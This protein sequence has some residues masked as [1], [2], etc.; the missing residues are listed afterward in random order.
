MNNPYGPTG[1]NPLEGGFSFEEE[2][3]DAP[4]KRKYKRRKK[5]STPIR[6]FTAEAWAEMVQKVIEAR[7]KGWSIAR[8]ARNLN[9]SHYRVRQALDAGGA[10]KMMVNNQYTIGSS[11]LGEKDAKRGSYHIKGESVTKLRDEKEQA[12]LDLLHLIPSM[13]A[14]SAKYWLQTIAELI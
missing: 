14:P 5:R 4:K 7:N 3:E 9:L 13:K 1:N 11:P 10:P 12:I 6:Q 8:C 2:E